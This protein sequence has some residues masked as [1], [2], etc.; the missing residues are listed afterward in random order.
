MTHFCDDF[1]GFGKRYGA[2]RTAPPTGHKFRMM[3][4]ARTACEATSNEEGFRM[5]SWEAGKGES[6]APRTKFCETFDK[7]LEKHISATVGY[8]LVNAK[9]RLMYS[10]M[11]AAA[12]GVRAETQHLESTAL[13]ETLQLEHEETTYNQINK[14]NNVSKNER[15]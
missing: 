14:Y 5:A 9:L 8:H 6:L 3:K 4:A 2:R 11:C 1:F 15:E 13:V 7:H 12:L 10:Q